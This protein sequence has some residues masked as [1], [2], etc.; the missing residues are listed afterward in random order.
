MHRDCL[1]ACRPRTSVWGGVDAGG[2]RNRQQATRQGRLPRPRHPAGQGIR[3]VNLTSFEGGRSDPGPQ[4]TVVSSGVYRRL[5]MEC[6]AFRWM[7]A[8]MVPV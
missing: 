2:A 3:K 7:G 8:P 6:V 5:S 1:L 4:V